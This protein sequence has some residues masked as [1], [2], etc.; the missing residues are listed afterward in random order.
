MQKVAHA[1]L[2]EHENLTTTH[3]HL[4]S[5]ALSLTTPPSRCQGRWHAA[6][7]REVECHEWETDSNRNIGRW[8]AFSLIIQSR[9]LYPI[10]HHNLTVHHACDACRICCA[11]LGDMISIVDSPSR[12]LRLAMFCKACTASLAE[13]G[14]THQQSAALHS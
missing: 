10:T 11:I 4:A 7:E 9:C 5:H 13:S 3:G 6:H 1:T 8:S 2:C 12:T 14:G